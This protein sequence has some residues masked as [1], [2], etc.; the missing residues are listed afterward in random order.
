MVRKPK[1]PPSERSDLIRLC[2][3]KIIEYENARGR[4]TWQ[5]RELDPKYV[6]GSLRYQVLKNAKFRC[7]LC[8]ISAEEKNTIGKIYDCK[9]ENTL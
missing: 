3:D 6:P 5:H 7:E 1:P 8:G 9:N 2:E 4:V